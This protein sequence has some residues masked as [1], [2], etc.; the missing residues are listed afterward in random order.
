MSGKSI[1]FWWIQRITGLVMLPL[2]FF[3]VYLF[4]SVSGS[5]DGLYAALEC[6]FWV[7]LL[8]MIFLVVVFYHGVLG[9]Q[10]VLEDYVHSEILRA[11]LITF[12][13]ICAVVTVVTV[14]TVLFFNPAACA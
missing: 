2:P 11:F 5:T 9:V 14:F 4:S 8:A 1:Y 13:K 12:V 3:F 7:R 10:V 6:G